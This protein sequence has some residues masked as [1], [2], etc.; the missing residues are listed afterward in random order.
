MNS[1]PDCQYDSHAGEYT[2]LCHAEKK[3]QNLYNMNLNVM[4][5]YP[6]D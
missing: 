3:K 4:S 2:N 5:K 6:Y 1:V